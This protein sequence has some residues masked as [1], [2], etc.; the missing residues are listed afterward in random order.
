MFQTP[1]LELYFSKRSSLSYY[2]LGSYLILNAIIKTLI[3]SYLLSIILVSSG[4]ITYMGLYHTA[5]CID[6]RP[7]IYLYNYTL[8][9]P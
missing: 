6:P 3:L 8:L 7:L 5:V 2:F 9:K 4:I 1:I